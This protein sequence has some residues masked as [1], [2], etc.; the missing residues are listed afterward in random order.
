M[1]TLSI[2]FHSAQ[3]TMLAMLNVMNVSS[4]PSTI[5]VGGR[6]HGFAGPVG[7]VV[8]YTLLSIVGVI[9]GPLSH[10]CFNGPTPRM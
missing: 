4:G 8:H 2:L 7:I 10:C 9:W 3:L 5:I 6:L 1:P